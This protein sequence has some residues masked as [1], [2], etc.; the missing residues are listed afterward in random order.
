MIKCLRS[1]FGIRVFPQ[2]GQR[3]FTAGAGAVIRNVTFRAAAD[4]TYLLTIPF[5]VVRDE[6][7]ISPVLTEVGD[8]REFI[9]LELLVCGEMGIIESQLLKGDISA[10]K[11]KKPTDLFMLVLN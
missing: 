3:S 2:C 11:V 1:F 5:F 9:N 7:L 10:D 4:R 6:F 8:Q